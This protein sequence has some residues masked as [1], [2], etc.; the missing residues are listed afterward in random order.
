[1]T[2]AGSYTR[3]E[4]LQGNTYSFNDTTPSGR[5]GVRLKFNEMSTIPY[6]STMVQ[7]FSVA[8]AKPQFAGR[9]PWM[10]SQRVTIAQFGISTLNADISFD[11]TMIPGIPAP[12]RV[13][14][15]QRDAIGMGIFSPLATTYNSVRNE[16][17]ATTSRLGEFIFCWTDTDTL[18]STPI[19]VSPIDRD[20][21]N[22]KLP[23]VLVWNPKG[24]V[25]G[26]HVQ[27]AVDSLFKTLV[28][29]DSLL[30]SPT[31]TLR[32]ISNGAKYY[33]RVRSRNY[34]QTSGR[35]AIRWL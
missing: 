11:A 29:S 4:L 24:Y 34:G 12:D 23:L 1:M 33:W 15:Y 27:V 8:P 26:F 16:I 19:L 21:V 3:Y 20:S 22:Q 30:T 17:V 10:A 31:D 14:V 32:G 25:T 35:S 28:L 7:R 13:T 5:T 2:P 18:A 9:S 6:N